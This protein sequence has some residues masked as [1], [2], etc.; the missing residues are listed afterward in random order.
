MTEVP[1]TAIHRILSD[2]ETELTEE[3]FLSLSEPEQLAYFISVNHSND[4]NER[5][6]K[7]LH[8]A[9]QEQITDLRFLNFFIPITLDIDLLSQFNRMEYYVINLNFCLDTFL[10][11]NRVFP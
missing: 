4:L 3:R 5:L 6:Y 9:N 7:I 1:D 10:F 8:E 11:N 2:R